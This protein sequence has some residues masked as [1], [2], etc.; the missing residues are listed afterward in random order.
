MHRKNF[1]LLPAVRRPRRRS[2]FV[3]VTVITITAVSVAL[4]GLWARA[5]VLEHRR[6]AGQ[7]FRIQA[8]RL[9]EAGVR[10]A[11]PQLSTD[12]RYGT[13]TWI[14]P[15]EDLDQLHSAEV[16]IRVAPGA[17]QKTFDIEAVAEFPTDSDRRAQS[18][19]RISI[20]NAN[21]GTKP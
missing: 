21:K 2:A 5:A 10:R 4:F 12:S 16:Q 3:L 18:T 20:P 6:L 13:E 15:A 1:R 8:V 9:A 7:Q 11:A 17:D 19:K 14:I